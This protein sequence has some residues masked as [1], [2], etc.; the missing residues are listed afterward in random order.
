MMRFNKTYAYEIRLVEFDLKAME[1]TELQ[2][3]AERFAETAAGVLRSSDVVLSHSTDK[4]LAILPKVDDENLSIPT[5]R[6]LDEW[7]KNGDPD[8]TVTFISKSF[9]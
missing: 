7:Q 4:V 3:A 1:G 5:R 9:M 2:G 6:V 8:V